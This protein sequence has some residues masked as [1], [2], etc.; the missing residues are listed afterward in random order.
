M[1]CQPTVCIKCKQ[2]FP[3]CQLVNNLCP[4]CRPHRFTFIKK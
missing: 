2:T 3:A 4:T 1:S